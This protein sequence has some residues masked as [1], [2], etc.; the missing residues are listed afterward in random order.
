[1]TAQEISERIAR[2]NEAYRSGQIT[3]KEWDELMQGLIRE[4]RETG[5]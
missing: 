2:F 3:G 5:R 1:M 4:V